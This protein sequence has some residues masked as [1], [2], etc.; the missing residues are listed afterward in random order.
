MEKLARLA[1]IN[2]ISI[3]HQA[4]RALIRYVKDHRTK[5]LENPTFRNVPKG[6]IAEEE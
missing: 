4:R 1:K 2:G 6:Y 3:G 5:L